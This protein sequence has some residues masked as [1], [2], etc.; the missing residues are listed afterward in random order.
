LFL[1][2]TDQIIVLDPFTGNE[3]NRIRQMGEVADLA[4]SPDGSTLFTAALRAI[5][6]F[7][8][9]AMKDISGEEII[10]AACSRLTHNFSASEWIL[11]F[12]DEEYRALCES[13][14]AP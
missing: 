2:E 7:D 5:Q 11:F 13:L 3:V 8:L 6:Y 4:F 14:P 9:D 10:T 1:G 12:E